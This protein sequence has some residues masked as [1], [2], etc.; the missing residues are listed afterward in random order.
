[1]V[2]RSLDV[3][4]FSLKKKKKLNILSGVHSIKKTVQFKGTVQQDRSGQN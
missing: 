3:Q 4:I 2:Q 1:M